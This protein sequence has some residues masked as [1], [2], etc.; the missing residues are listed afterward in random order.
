MLKGGLTL[1]GAANLLAVNQNLPFN[2]AQLAWDPS[3]GTALPGYP[4]ATDDFQLLGQASVAR[5]GGG[6]PE[7]Q[8]LVGTGLY[9]LHAYGPTGTEP[10][11]WPKF[12]G[13]W[14]QATPAVGDADGDGDLDV[15]TVTREGWSFLWDTAATPGDDDGVDAC[16]D[17]NEEWWTFHHDE[18]S[19]NN[20]RGDGR[21]PY[22]PEDL[23]VVRGPGDRVD[24]S[25]DAPGDDWA[26]GQA[27]VFRVIVSPN[28]ITKPT[29]GSVAAQ[30]GAAAASGD[31]QGA[32]LTAAE[33][34]GNAHLA[35][36]FR[37]EAGNWGRLRSAAIPPAG[38]G[39]G[40]ADG[41]GD[42]DDIDNCAAGPEPRPGGR[43]RGRHRRRLRGRHR[44][45]RRH[46][47][48]RQLRRDRQP[49]PGGLRRRRPRQRLR[50]DP[51]RAGH[52]RRRR[53]RR[54][55]RR[56]RQPAGSRRACATPRS[57]TA[58]PDALTGTTAGDLIRGL[59]GRDR[60][61]GGD[62]DDCLFGNKGG[63]RI[64]ATPAPTSLAAATAAT[65][66]SAARERTRSAPARAPT[67]SAP[68]TARPT[69]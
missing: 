9:N 33:V 41:D 59:R 31:T 15:T 66:S 67:R 56:D 39:G 36:F 46:R 8:M 18:R 37:D 40:D 19:T 38:G 53:W 57:G 62:G 16:D 63:D 13:G 21:P 65:G 60:I 7:R 4:I 48:H 5:V 27:D 45:R 52:P 34:A 44:R 14:Q 2:H 6:G 12:T 35:V 42:P 61:G 11:G 69:G 51:E 54:R 58:G 1:N 28:P 32:I 43:R 24:L 23:Q 20:Y 22:R 50:P 25:V 68:A 30:L 26:C 55:R 10:A 17:S 3:T 49:G 64:S 29:D 47:R